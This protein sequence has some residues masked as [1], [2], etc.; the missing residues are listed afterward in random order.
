MSAR[1]AFIA[2]VLALI[3]VPAVLRLLLVPQRGFGPDELEHSHFAWRLLQ[4]QLPYRDYFDHHTP[5]FHFLLAGLFARRDVTASAEEAI[6]ALFDARRLAWIFGSL[7]LLA[8][9]LLGRVVR[10]PRE[11][12]LAALLLGNTSVFLW[13]AFESRPDVPAM[14]LVTLALLLG[15]RGF[16]ELGTG[17][18]PM[19]QL[20]ASGLALGSAA[21]FTQKVLFFGPG[22]ALFS[23]LLLCE[24][25]LGA[26]RAR[27]VEALATLGFGFLVPIVATLAYFAAHG[28]LRPFVECNLLVN[29]RWPGLPARDFVFLVLDEDPVTVS[30]CA[31]GGAMGLA[32]PDANGLLRGEPFLVLAFLSAVLGLLVHPAVTLHYFLLFLPLAAV[33]AAAALVALADGWTR[34]RPAL[35]ADVVLT[36]F[37]LAIS[38]LPAVRLREAFTRGNWSTLQ[39]LRWVMANSAPWETTLDGFSGLGAFRP[40]AFYHPFVNSHTRYVMGAAEVDAMAASLRSGRVLPR[41]AFLDNDLREGLNPE[42]L[43]FVE[44]HYSGIHQEPI[45]ARLFDA[46][47]GFWSDEGP[48]PIGWVRGVERR[49]HVFV[50]DGWRVPMEEDGV[51]VRRTRTR[52]S[53]LLFPLRRPRDGC[54]VL[55]ARADAEAMPFAFEVLANGHQLGRTEA[56]AGWQEYRVEAPAAALRIGFNAIALRFDP[57]QPPE[58][59]RTELAVEWISFEA[60]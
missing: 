23:L 60:P 37:A 56:R 14:L 20:L 21:M 2:V 57:L 13:R 31:I 35:S 28:A 51:A 4:G 39:G 25:R 48:R 36:V 5:F 17:R 44:K 30:L 45:R 16:R 24:P 41:I 58:D 42:A 47:L 34:R 49:P 43:A 6:A 40:A 46:G 22:M 9:A 3:A 27:R 15:V 11:G 52:R 26:P 29:T 8:T 12:L 55:R 53:V 54:L 38:V 7:A 18:A 1:R 50:G 19:T 59:R 10:G 33:Y 32:R